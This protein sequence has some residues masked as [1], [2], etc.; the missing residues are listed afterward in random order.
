MAKVRDG[1]RSDCSHGWALWGEKNSLLWFMHLALHIPGTKVWEQHLGSALQLLHR[2]LCLP[3]ELPC[4]RSGCST[5]TTG[6]CL[7]LLTSQGLKND[8]GT[9]DFWAQVH[10]AP[11]SWIWLIPDL[12][13]RTG[14]GKQ[15]QWAAVSPAAVSLEECF[16]VERTRH[17]TLCPAWAEWQLW[18]LWPNHPDLP[19][20]GALAPTP[21]IQEQ[22]SQGLKP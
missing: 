6:H 7:T 17:A 16:S 20:Q 10:T 2:Y 12:Q 13:P 14:T 21:G 22:E 9:G 3:A 8:P 15:G 5:S 19:W 4:P 11:T 18:Q 1:H